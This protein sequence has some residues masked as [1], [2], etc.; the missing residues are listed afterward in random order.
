MKKKYRIAIGAP[1]YDG[2]D[3]DTAANQIIFSHY[4]GRLQERLWWIAATQSMWIDKKLP[5]LDPISKS[6]FSEVPTSLFGTEFEFVLCE[7]MGC[8]L[9]GMARERVV[10]IAMNFGCDYLL[11]YDD[12]MLFGTDAFLRLFLNQV[13]VCAALAFTGREPIAPVIYKFTNEWDDVRKVDSV[14]IQVVFEYERNALQKVDAVGGGMVLIDMEVFKQIQKPW[15]NSTG[16]GEDIFFCYQCGRAGVP[17][18]VDTRVK[19][20][21]KPTF[22][23]EWHDEVKFERDY[24]K[25]KREAGVL[26]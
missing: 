15:F 20:L 24:A 19:T 4:L 10:D 6:G 9:I 8:S 18:Y 12:D 3:R 7:E 23:T 2:P 11:F 17:V 25:Q 21:H 5:P 26:A 1:W 13:P 14:N 16:M 22:P